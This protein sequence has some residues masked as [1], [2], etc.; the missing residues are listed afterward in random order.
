MTELC[1]FGLRKMVGDIREPNNFPESKETQLGHMKE[2][3]Q[4]VRSTKSRVPTPAPPQQEQ[5]TSPFVPPTPPKNNDMY[6]R[7]YEIRDT[8]YTDQTGKSPHTSIR[9][10][11][12]Q[13]ILHNFDSNTTWVETLRDRKSGEPCICSPLVLSRRVS[14]HVVSLS[15]SWRIIWYFLPRL[16]VWG[17]FPVWLVYM[18]SLVL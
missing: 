10:K 1:F 5:G 14:S 2:K 4:N 17:N 13:M 9:S 3:R 11:K 15:K 8:V 7:V 12:Y 16:D 6:L 18:V